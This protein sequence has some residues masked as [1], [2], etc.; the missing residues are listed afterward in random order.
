[1]GAA[2]GAGGGATGGSMASSARRSLSPTRRCIT[3]VRASAPPSST[4]S[5]R[6]RFITPSIVR[7]EQRPNP[8][9]GVPRTRVALFLLLHRLDD[10]QREGLHGSRDPV[11]VGEL[12]DEHEAPD[13]EALRR[14]RD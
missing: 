8:T 6:R 7:G 4:E 11:L 10:L 13:L 2:A 5:I 3:P 14:Q 12:L 9:R 1:M